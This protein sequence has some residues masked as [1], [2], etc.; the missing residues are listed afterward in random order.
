VEAES[1]GDE[2]E[3]GDKLGHLD[4]EANAGRD[5]G[6]ARVPRAG[7]IRERDERILTLIF[8]SVY[9][10]INI[11]YIHMRDNDP[12]IYMYKRGKIY[13]EP[14]KNTIIKMLIHI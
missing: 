6:G 13:K 1:P 10:V 5:W 14:Y 8:D 2:A 12:N 9:H 4:N 7:S 3:P 11:T